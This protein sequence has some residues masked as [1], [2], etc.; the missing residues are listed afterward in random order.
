MP[1]IEDVRL[2]RSLPPHSVAV[3]IRKAAGVSQEQLADELGVHPQT[4]ARWE[5]GRRVPRGE[6][7]LRYAKLLSELAGEIAQP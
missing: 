4:V 1:L 7:R 2:A 3:A 5:Q 6:L